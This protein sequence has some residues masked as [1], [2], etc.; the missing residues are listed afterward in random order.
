MSPFGVIHVLIEQSLRYIQLQSTQLFSKLVKIFDC[1]IEKKKIIIKNSDLQFR[2]LPKI[3]AGK[4][5]NKSDKILCYLSKQLS[6]C[7]LYLQLLKKKKKKNMFTIIFSSW[8]SE[9]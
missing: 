6:T 4:F 3:N 7:M 5:E 2:E 8:Q 1:S 9:H